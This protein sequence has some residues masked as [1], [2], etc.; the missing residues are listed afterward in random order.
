MFNY[1]PSERILDAV[2]D[3]IID[4]RDALLM[5]IKWMGEDDLEEMLRAN[6]LLF[7]DDIED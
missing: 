4:A 6:D 3:G 1:P 7:D 2:D 5:C